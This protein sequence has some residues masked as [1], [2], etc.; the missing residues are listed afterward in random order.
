MEPNNVGALPL[1]PSK[2][3]PSHKPK[4]NPATSPSSMASMS[5]SIKSATKVVKSAVKK[6]NPV[7]TPPPKNKI[8]ERKFVVAK[9]SSKREKLET[10]GYVKC[11]C[12]AN[13]SSKKCVC[14]CVAYESL[15]A[16]QDEFSMIGNVIGDDQKEN[17]VGNGA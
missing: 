4:P 10:L 7:S 12:E 15:R 8:R 6:P 9:K 16:S 17:V 2:S 3:K 1:T 14:V 13:S 11:K 5:P